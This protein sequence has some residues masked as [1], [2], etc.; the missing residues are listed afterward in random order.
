MFL[1]FVLLT[2]GKFG[3]CGL[4]QRL[5]ESFLQNCSHMRFSNNVQD[6]WRN[7]ANN[8]VSLQAY[9]LWKTEEEKDDDDD[10]ECRYK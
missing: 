1:V 4:S 3:D 10:D 2:S 5:Q 8:K 9:S 7:T 6:W